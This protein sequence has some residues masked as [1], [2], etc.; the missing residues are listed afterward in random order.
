M[1]I[2]GIDVGGTH[3]DGVLLN[4]QKI[5]KFL[6]VPY[7]K[8]EIIKYI[9]NML[10]ELTIGIKDSEIENINLS[11]TI[12]TN[13]I[14]NDDGER[15][16]LI[17]ESGIGIVN[18]F[19]Y[20][21]ADIYEI[22]SYVNHMG[23][24]V[25][26]LN[27]NELLNI[28]NS[29]K[30]KDNLAVVCKFSV[31]NPNHEL[32]IKE[33]FNEFNFISLGHSLSGNLNFKR[34]VDTTFLNNYIHKAFSE[35]A[36][37]IKYRFKNVYVLK[38]DG[39]TLKLDE[40]I[41]KPVE[42]IMSGVAASFMGMSALVDFNGDSVLFD[43]GGSTTDVFFV[44]DNKALFKPKGIDIY[45]YK[46]QISSIYSYSIPLGGDSRIIF[47][48]EYKLSKR[49]DFAAGF[50]GKYPTLSDALIIHNKLDGDY[51]LAYKAIASLNVD[52]IKSFSLEIINK[53]INIIY[54]S[55]INEIE[56]INNQP[57]YTIS[58]VLENKKF[59]IN[60][61]VL[62]GGLASG[63]SDYFNDKFN[64]DASVVKHYAYAN[65]LGAALSN[66][67]SE[68]NII[69]N[70][71][72]KTLIASEYSYQESIDRNYTLEDAKALAKKLLK[73]DDILIVEANSFNML[74]YYERANKNIRVKAQIMPSLRF[75][76][77]E[78][79]NE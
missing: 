60:S 20:L 17:I 70:T 23:K 54:E 72:L 30:D 6:K 52:N 33:Y 40:A 55:V 16:N 48:K 5:V 12:T 49:E 4:D 61:I 25:I 65:A 37:S 50:G 34:R 21:D 39:G 56:K 8:S 2:I 69:A 38:A 57:M 46:T 35:F 43:I 18:D 79:K 74:S 26:K 15:V 58:E 51:D 7:I 59:N 10:D 62:S 1:Y 32:K 9:H 67:T 3:I 27:N 76:L 63:L 64:V 75:D 11:T 44:V 19:S 73:S 14:Y 29:I 36:D 41:N 31:R 68:V 66:I 71:K 28:K 47:D 45:K 42:T 77:K 22:S 13:A 53:Y 78:E 24:E